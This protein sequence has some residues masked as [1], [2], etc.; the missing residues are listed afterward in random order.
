MDIMERQES[1]MAVTCK[2]CAMF[3]FLPE[4]DVVYI[5]NKCKLVAL[6]EE[7]VR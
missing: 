3:V 4:I 6:L 1:E 5:C 2:V 7:K